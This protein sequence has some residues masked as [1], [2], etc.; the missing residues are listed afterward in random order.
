[1][2]T[3]RWLLASVAVFVVLAVLDFIIHG[4]LLHGV[5]QQTASLWRAPADIQRLMWIFWAGY[6]VFA[7]FF[8]FIY[9]QGYEKDKSGVG[10]G[11]RFGLYVGAMLSVLHGFGW[12]VILPIPLTL[13]VYWF[14]AT[15][16]ESIAMG[17]TAGL[18]YR[19]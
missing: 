16:V 12:Y 8:V 9:T 14:V 19:A 5:Y 2:N 7:T 1:M 11:F 15:L 17:I 6:L 18:V 10:Q 13:S 4:V 3:R